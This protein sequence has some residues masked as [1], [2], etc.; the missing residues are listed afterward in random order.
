MSSNISPPLAVSEARPVAPGWLRIALANLRH[1]PWRLLN[2]LLYPAY[3]WYEHYLDAQVATDPVPAHIGLILDGNRRFAR[4]IGLEAMRGHQYGVDKLREVLEWCLDL[5]VGHVTLYV[6][7]TENFNRA[8][9]EVD[10]LLD[11]FVRE[12]A[13]L[14]QE[15]RMKN[16]RVRVKIIGQRERLPDRVVAASEALELST[17]GHDGMLLTIALAYSGRE[18]ITDAVKG[19]LN[20]AAA[21]GSSLEALSASLKAEDI[22]RYLYTEGTPDPDFIIRTSGEQRLSGFL[23]WQAAYSEFYFCDV[24]WPAFRRIDFLRAVRTYQRR[25]RRYGR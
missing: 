22:Q 12:S 17:A 2:P 18:E 11:L 13:R 5:D 25:N 21:S 6:F 23:L 20:A 1:R 9:D 16:G 10:S 7:S 24:L 4:D 15:P 3:R 19:L 8:Q 14:L